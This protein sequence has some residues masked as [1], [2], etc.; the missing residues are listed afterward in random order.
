VGDID[1]NTT[2]VLD[3][4]QRACTE[5]GADLVVFPELVL[6]AYPPEDL[7]LRPSL[8]LRIERAL[9]RICAA[10]L[11]ATLVIGYPGREDGKLYNMLTCIRGGEV[12]GSYRKQCLPNYQVFDEKRYF[13]AGPGE[14]FVLEL[15]GLPIAFTV[16]EDLWEREPMAHARTAGAKLM[17][18][19]NGSPY[20]VNK[21]RER[22]EVMQQRVRE[23]GMP[24]VYVN[25]V[26]G[27]DELVFDGASMVMNAEGEVLVQAPQFGAA[28]LPVEVSVQNGEC[29]FPALP[30]PTPLLAAEAELY[31]ALVLGLRDYVEKNHFR[32]VVLGL[33]GGVDSALTLALAVDAIGPER[34]EAVMMPYAYTAQMSLDDAEAEARALGVSYKVLPIGPMVESFNEALAPEFVGLP[35][36][37]TEQNL[38]A[39]CRGVLL[40]A[41]SNKKGLL[42]LTTGNKSEMAVGYST[43]YGDM[44]G[45]FDVLKDVP[46][47]KVYALSHYRNTIALVIPERVLTRPPSAELAPGQ[48]DED[49]LPP[50]P[51]LDRILELYV[52]HDQSSEAIIGE[53]FARATVERVLKMVDRNE[54]KRRQAPVGV[55]I[56][57]RG[58]GRD[59]RYPITSNWK[60]GD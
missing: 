18:N 38:Q 51:E 45:G 11:P 28:L 44:A 42:V 48:V 1:G 43:L 13:Q 40:M 55:R 27:Q 29:S 2:L 16:C 57:Q 56:S 26:G 36:D 53:G 47:M 39:R 23:G 41:L 37:I 50:Y 25:Q 4:A 58:F 22:R 14:A 49:N 60:V 3:A 20:H 59:R 24:L 19:I 6:T 7:L 30:A 21:V 52:E 5:F 12:L 9:A 34:V 31:A 46:K 35:S 15:H 10:R 8:D 32:G 54:Y 17:V 33:S